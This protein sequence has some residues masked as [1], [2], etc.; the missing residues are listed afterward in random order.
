MEISN[1]V[2]PQ[3][4]FLWHFSRQCLAIVMAVMVT[5]FSLDL[6]AESEAAEF[7]KVRTELKLGIETEARDFTSLGGGTGE[8]FKRAAAAFFK[9]LPASKSLEGALA[10]MI[11]G[12]VL[13]SG[14]FNR[15]VAVDVSKWNALTSLSLYKTLREHALKD[16]KK[17]VAVLAQQFPGGEATVRFSGQVCGQ[18]A[19]LHGLLTEYANYDSETRTVEYCDRFLPEAGNWKDWQASLSSNRRT[20]AS[21]E[22]KDSIMPVAPDASIESTRGPA[23]YVAPRAGLPKKAGKPARTQAVGSKITGH[24]TQTPVTSAPVGNA[25]LPV[26]KSRLPASVEDGFEYRVQ[27]GKLISTFW[28]VKRAD[29]YDLLYVN[30]AGSKTSLDLPVESFSFLH[31]AAESIHPDPVDLRKC[32]TTSMQIHVVSNHQPERSTAACVQGKNRAAIE[33]RNLGSLLSS[34]VR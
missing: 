16:A 5:T 6:K 14:D 30:S 18:D 1:P 33:L 19:D 4:P 29:H 21:E 10:D 12:D 24:K 8:E 23:S 15:V 26:R 2:R 22:L 34:A 31:N 9:H 17:K 25:A 32:P 27:Y 11:L 13:P 28:V 3:D 20:P 7:S